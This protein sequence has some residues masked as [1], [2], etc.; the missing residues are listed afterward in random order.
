[1]SDD[2]TVTKRNFG[3]NQ[4]DEEKQG[5][6]N[7]VEGKTSDTRSM[8]STAYLCAGRGE[9]KHFTNQASCCQGT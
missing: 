7:K 8:K 5:S 3:G 2:R 9:D 6:K 4:M 1:M